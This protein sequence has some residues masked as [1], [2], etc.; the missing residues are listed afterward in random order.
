MDTINITEEFKS[1]LQGLF[2]GLLQD[3]PTAPSPLTVVQA[4]AQIWGFCRQIL[5]EQELQPVEKILNHKEQL[6]ALNL[7]MLKKLAEMKTANVLDK[8]ALDEMVEAYN[9][10]QQEMA[11]EA[12]AKTRLKPNVHDQVKQAIEQY[13]KNIAAASPEAAAAI[14]PVVD[15]L[16]TQA[17]LD[18]ETAIKNL[19]VLTA[20][21]AK[22]A[23]QPL[24]DTQNIISLTP[25]VEAISSVDLHVQNLAET[26]AAASNLPEQVAPVVGTVAVVAKINNLQPQTTSTLL[27][28]FVPSLE[29]SSKQSLTLP[30][31]QIAQIV[32]DFNFKATGD[33][34]IKQT[35]AAQFAKVGIEHKAANQLAQEMVDNRAHVIAKAIAVRATVEGA[36]VEENTKNRLAAFKSAN[37]AALEYLSRGP[38]GQAFMIREAVEG[39]NW[40]PVMEATAGFPVG[41]LANVQQ[42]YTMRNMRN[43]P[44]PLMGFLLGQGQ[45]WAT[46]AVTKKAA[47]GLAKWAA[48]KGLIKA[49]ATIAAPEIAVPLQAASWAKD[50]GSWALRTIKNNWQPIAF[51]IGGA[52]AALLAG[53]PGIGIGAA[54]AAGGAVGT[55]LTPGGL[56]RIGNWLSNGF[57]AI[58]GLAYK[59]P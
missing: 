42:F 26:A 15:S 41:D 40:S 8:G 30:S 51:A 34:L 45:S 16:A 54:A 57:N 24:S 31:T 5:T 48:E 59:V 53:F 47:A 2:L 29:A 11:Q 12:A 25:V 3:P 55:S 17:E 4:E 38:K 22:Q 49:A 10:H 13:R 1:Q 20:D 9:K 18:P 36:S 21:V 58:A 28:S 27:E 32:K 37:N 44:S 35:M 50:L 56:S 52:G 14:E 33:E 39:M 7:A 46:S 6:L 23:G 43:R 19:T